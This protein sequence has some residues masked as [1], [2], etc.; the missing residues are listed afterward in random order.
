MSEPSEW[1]LISMDEKR[2][3][4]QGV[5]ARLPVPRSETDAIADKG[6]TLD[7]IR[8]W[9]RDF[10]AYASRSPA[11]KNEN[12]ALAKSLEAFVGK[13]E[14]L[15]R[16]EQAFGRGDYAKAISTLRMIASVDPDD[17][18]TKMNLGSALANTGDN[19]GALAQLE[20]I[21]ATF[22]GEA[23]Y[24]LVVGQ[25]QLA[26]GQM[27]KATDEFVLALEGNPECKAAMDALVKLGVLLAIYENPRDAE[28]LLYVRA[29]GVLSFVK[30]SWASAPRD[31]AFFLEQAEYH[32]AEGRAEVALAAAVEAIAK[33][34][35]A[36]E[37]ARAQVARIA[38]L[39][40]LGRAGEARQDVEAEAGGSPGA[41][42]AHCELARFL[43]DD[44]RHE[45]ARQEI[46][47]ALAIDPSDQTALTLRFYPTDPNDLGEMSL[48]APALAAFAEAHSD[49]PGPWRALGRMK[50][51]L[52]ADDEALGFLAK[53]VNLAPSDDVTR[54]E[55]W[56]L[57]ERLRHFDV[58][59]NQA[60]TLSDLAKRDWRLRFSEAEAYRGLG[61]KVEARAAFAA[62]NRDTSLPVE[63]RKRAKRA[64]M[65]M[66]DPAGD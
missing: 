21:R 11:W 14:L 19:A 65:S 18:A 37:M 51:A 38:A 4:R 55:Q 58:I 48:A 16:A 23:D 54:A 63:V 3:R 56:A 66:G 33:G 7:Q 2:A 52:G 34:G 59:V 27:D 62:L 47:R 53:A 41:A 31:A 8:R 44:G 40:S 35:T 9:I 22:A 42:W 36:E 6:M 25:I 32:Q 13:T 1:M 46:D 45:E 29:D 43:T 15:A 20:P 50:A 64:V 5:P 49:Q 17:H 61:K 26:L 57:L 24:H 30:G 28:S 60:A 39:R 12:A 10:L